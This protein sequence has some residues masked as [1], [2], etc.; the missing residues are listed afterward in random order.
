MG[1]QTID[2]KTAKQTVPTERVMRENLHEKVHAFVRDQKIQAPLSLDNLQQISSNLLDHYSIEK[3]YQDYVTILISNEIWTDKLATIPFK[4]RIFL[5][6]QCLKN[7]E[8]CKAEMDEFGLLCENCGQCDIGPLQEYAESL[9]YLSLVAEGTTV[10][11]KL[12][13]SNQIDAVVGV[14]CIATLERS[15]P[16]TNALAVPAIAVSLNK[17]GCVNTEVDVDTVH[18]YLNLTSPEPAPQPNHFNTIKQKVLTW[19]EREN[20]EPLMGSP[21]T[22][23]E[24][25]AMGWMLAGG[26]RLRP[27]IAACVYNA[28]TEKDTYEPSFQKLAIA[29]ECFHKASLIH[30]DIEDN[31][32]QRYHKTVPH[33]IHGVP[34]ALNI[35]DLLLGDGYRLIAECDLDSDKKTK[36]LACASLAHREL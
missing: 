35:G 20:L 29:I 25:I 18:H 1:D 17:N 6:P 19:F 24:T 12:L 34:V 15:F 8:K 33:K 14:S 31:D 5:I 11:T 36:L 30:D 26:K 10:V 21:T 32:S 22:E 4:R 3:T 16:Y 13:E 27:I 2:I 7:Q 23:T 28:L 9:G